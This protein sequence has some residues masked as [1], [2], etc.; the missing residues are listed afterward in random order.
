MCRGD[1]RSA[2]VTLTAGVFRGLAAGEVCVSQATDH[3]SLWGHM[4]SPSLQETVKDLVVY[5]SGIKP[6]PKLEK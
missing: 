2:G 4:T 5:W 6:L 1:R 3:Q